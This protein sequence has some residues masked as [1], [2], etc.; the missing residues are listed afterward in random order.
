M[1]DTFTD[2]SMVGMYEIRNG[3]KFVH[4]NSEKF[5]DRLTIL[6]FMDKKLTEMEIEEWKDFSDNMK[7]FK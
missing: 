6:I 4:I 5:R 2:F 3:T 7:V 1:M